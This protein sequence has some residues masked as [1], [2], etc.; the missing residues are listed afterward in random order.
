MRY[1]SQPAQATELQASSSD[2][3][4]WVWEQIKI[5]SIRDF[6]KLKCLKGQI[7]EAG[8]VADTRYVLHDIDQEAKEQALQYHSERL[9]IAYGLIST[10]PRTTLRIMKNLRICDDCHNAIKIMSKFAGWELIVRDKNTF[11]GF[12]SI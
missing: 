10:P 3:E 2:D 1:P 9:A 5:Y 8:Y 6:E 4:A 12:L 7:R 11:N